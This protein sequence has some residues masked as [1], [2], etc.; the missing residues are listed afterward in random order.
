M[1]H[2]VARNWPR[3]EC[4]SCFIREN[5]IL[6]H[7]S[8]LRSLLAIVCSWPPSWSRRNP[9]GASS[10]KGGLDR[11]HSITFVVG[12]VQHIARSCAFAKPLMMVSWLPTL[13]LQPYEDIYFSINRCCGDGP[14]P[15]SVCF[16]TEAQ[17]K[18]NPHREEAPSTEEGQL[19]LPTILLDAS[20]H[21]SALWSFLM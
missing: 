14:T 20:W 12:K 13:L 1:R 17:G 21:C 6:S 15:K 8:Y 9:Y 4:S 18:G 7:V 2:D 19:Q 10:G 5:R 16:K 11:C 3:I